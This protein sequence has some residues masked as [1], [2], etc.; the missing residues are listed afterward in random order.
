MPNYASTI[1][2]LVVASL[3]VGWILKALNLD[4]RDLLSWLG[5]FAD[6]LMDV[7][8][9]FLGWAVGPILVGAVV[10]IPIWLIWLV[11]KKAMERR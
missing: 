1:I 10:V 9:G 7:F 3:I 2:K 4:A 5:S 11:W 6:K 8:A